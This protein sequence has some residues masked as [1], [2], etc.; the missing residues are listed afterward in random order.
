[1]IPW[2]LPGKMLQ[3]YH[4]KTW[5]LLWRFDFVTSRS[6]FVMIHDPWRLYD[7]KYIVTKGPCLSTF[8]DETLKK[9]HKLSDKHIIVT[10]NYDDPNCHNIKSKMSQAIYLWSCH[11]ACDVAEWHGMWHGRWR[12]KNFVMI[13]FVI[14]WNVVACD[15]AADV[16]CEMA[17]DVAKKL[18][19]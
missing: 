1:M 8:C 4:Y 14:E 16:A 19:F 3:W 2:I 11:V 15:M 5:Y 10:N 7:K 9:C 12:S 17:A 18:T 6:C 13:W